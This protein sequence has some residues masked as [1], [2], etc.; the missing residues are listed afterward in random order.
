MRSNQ[1]VYKTPQFEVLSENQRERIYSAALEVME[2]TGIR[3]QSKEAL[4]LLKEAGARINGEIARIPSYLVENALRS[5]PQ[6]VLIY[7]RDGDLAMRL[8]GSNSYFGTGSDCPFILDSFTGER[9][10]FTKKDIEQAAVICDALPNIN[11][12]MSMG[13]ISD[14]PASITD[15]H[16]F[17][18]M[19]FNTRKPIVFTSLGRRGAED[20]IK[21]AGI[22]VGSEEELSRRPFVIH[23]VE[24]SSP[25]TISK[26]AVDRLLLSADKGIPALF[27]PGSISGA[28]SPVTLAGTL[29]T[30]LAES[31]S[32]IVL[33]QLRREG[34]S[35]IMGGIS[36]IMDM[37]TTLSP[38]GGPEFY[39]LN[40]AMSE[41]CKFIKM[42][43]FGAAGCGDA[44]KFDEQAAIDSALSVITQVLSGA[45]LI[46]DIGYIEAGLTSSFD[47]LVLTNEIIDMV[48]R[49]MKG[50]NTDDEHL[51]L[52]VINKVGPGGNY[53]VED[54][55]LKHFREYW[56]PELMNRQNYEG[57]IEKGGKDLGERVNEK[58]K[59]ILA[60]YKTEPLED[61]K[62]RE[63]LKIIELWERKV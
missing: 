13:L 36:G 56:E 38:Y 58:V 53:L 37:R 39:L 14:K 10:K 25:L 34:L 8:E 57:W 18:A 15:L 22:I 50:I 23:Y 59:S 45:N 29:V 17:Q 20:I 63:I 11:F 51:A 30:S 28:T 31:L 24:P 48:K 32:G 33:S 60:E 2:H 6:K 27:T 21:M 19:T 43:V 1:K 52:E 26:D 54:H 4:S 49:F 7:T 5:A 61:K 35:L 3:I 46:H 44:N 9:R 62:Q 47:V 55:T 40:A 42:P 41:L 16:Q 12:M